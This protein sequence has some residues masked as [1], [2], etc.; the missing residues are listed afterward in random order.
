MPTPLSP[1]LEAFLAGGTTDLELAD[2]HLAAGRPKDAIAIYSA[3]FYESVEPER[4]AAYAARC[5]LEMR[6]PHEAL[7]WGR[8]VAERQRDLGNMLMAAAYCQLDDYAAASDVASGCDPNALEAVGLGREYAI[9]IEVASHSH[10]DRPAE[11]RA[12]LVAA[13]RRDADMPDLWAQLAI[14]TAADGLVPRSVLECIPT[15]NALSVFAWLGRGNPVG[16]ERILDAMWSEQPG[17]RLLLAVAADC[18]PRTPIDRAMEWSTRM[19]TV[20]LNS[21][22]PLRTLAS[23]DEFPA[24]ERVQAAVI[25]H[26]G[27][28]D[29]D[30]AELLQLACGAVATDEVETALTIVA[31]MDMELLETA[32]NGVVSDL[33]QTLVA[34]RYLHAGGAPDGA[35]AVVAHG[36]QLVDADPVWTD[37]AAAAA[38]SEYFEA[39]LVNE[40]VA[41][42]IAVGEAELATRLRTLCP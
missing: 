4:A 7:V 32:V 10:Q 31:E 25:V 42:F 2:E 19:R 33:P 22:C 23:G 18:A 37:L 36:L 34:A 38:F 27:F 6:V 24:L 40:L 30:A 3:A 14:V 21:L 41:G 11:A 5:C 29:S 15:D 16:A 39:A 13:L 26:V 20:G 8:W 35:L 28:Q 1:I 12:V 9:I 17:S